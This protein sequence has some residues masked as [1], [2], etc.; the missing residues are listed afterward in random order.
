MRKNTTT[1]QRT[2]LHQSLIDF[3]GG[4]VFGSLI[5]LILALAAF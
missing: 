1:P 5:V 2:S 3:A 4:A